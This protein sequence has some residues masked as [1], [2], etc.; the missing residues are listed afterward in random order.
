M[1]RVCVSWAVIHG[2]LACGSTT[3]AGKEQQHPVLL[4]TPV[5]VGEGNTGKGESRPPAPL[6]STE[7]A[8]TEVTH[9]L[10]DPQALSTADQWEFELQLHE[11]A[12][13]VARVSRKTFAQPV[14]SARQMGRFA[15]ELWIGRELI[16]RVRFDFP[17]LGVETPA[18]ERQA[19]SETPRFE[20]GLEASKIVLVP[21]ST[22]ATR[23]RLIDRATGKWQA[24]PWPPDAPLDPLSPTPAEPKNGA[25]TPPIPQ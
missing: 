10:P 12:I 2:A 25:E 18:G 22:R 23:A 21:H 15:I 6:A 5:P 13:D 3:L 8:R 7:P 17:L 20:P 9:E 24:L 16:D 4:S 11:G 14:V 19:V 1:S